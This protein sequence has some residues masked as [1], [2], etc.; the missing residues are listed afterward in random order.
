MPTLLLALALVS[1][2][3]PLFSSSSPR[4]WTDST[5]DV[6]LDGKLDRNV[7]TLSSTA[8]RMLAIVCGEEVVILDSDAKSVSRAK[9]ADF[10]F[11]AD[12]TK[13]TSAE[14][15]R[16][17]VAP[18]ARPDG[19]T[20]FAQ[21]DGKAILVTAHQSPSGAMTVEH[22]WDTV[23][24]WRS[25]ADAYK[26]DDKTV[27][28]LRAITEPVRLQ[29][30][31]ATWCGDSKYHVPRLLRAV[32]LADN[33]NLVVEL[34]G[35]GPDFT[36]PMEVVQKEHIT[37]V[38]MVI[39]RRG[40][41]EVGRMMETPAAATAADEIA[42]IVAGEQKPHPGRITRRNKLAEG[43][44]VWRGRKKARETFELYDTEKGGLIAHSVISRGADTIE[45]WAALDKDRRP[46]SA[47]VTY[48]VDGKLT[49]VRS[50]RDGDRWISISRGGDGGIIEQTLLVPDSFV[51]PATAL[52]GYAT[53]E[54]FIIRD[55][56]PTGIGAM[57]GIEFHA[58][59]HDTDLRVPQIVK[60]AD[61]SSRKLISLRR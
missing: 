47:E 19:S 48:R 55:D 58:K 23:P 52:Y 28:R 1:A 18:L 16:E 13:A 4:E 51:T 10:T 43:T 41:R 31:L 15:P 33:P 9:K 40:D 37:N 7:Q 3:S 32:E 54:A 26:P 22:L 49:R 38:P 56:V 14:I 21:V 20:Y 42:D 34:I 57:A 8:P 45:T 30:V 6:W 17:A 5:R 12:R 60:F 50:R 24:V 59:A 36:T 61:G 29:I 2:T 27:A 53:K 44:Y 35:V 11:T 25:I 46:V 39:V